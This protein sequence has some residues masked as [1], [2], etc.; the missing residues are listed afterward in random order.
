MQPGN[1]LFISW[2]REDVQ[3]VQEQNQKREKPKPETLE[4]SETT[5]KVIE[6]RHNPTSALS[7]MHLKTTLMQDNPRYDHLKTIQALKNKKRRRVQH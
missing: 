6:I 3:K 1:I 5:N 4:T 7:S 2:S